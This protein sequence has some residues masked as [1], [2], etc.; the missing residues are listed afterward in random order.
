M[1]TLRLAVLPRAVMLVLAASIVVVFTGSFV[2]QVIGALYDHDHIFGLLPLLHV[3]RE[4]NLAAWMS[5]T[6]MLLCSATAWSLATS[7]ES[8]YISR[9]APWKWVALALFLMSMDETAQVHERVGSLVQPLLPDVGAL[10]FG[11]VAVGAL[12]VLAAAPFFFRFVLSL[13][14]RTRIQFVMAATLFFAG[15]LGVE[16]VTGEYMSRTEAKLSITY[17]FLSHTEELLEMLGL[18][19]LLRALLEYAGTRDSHD[20]V[21]RLTTVD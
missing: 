21:E 17:I 7:T 15:A 6:T 12:V 1:M 18:F 16:M 8:K 10:Y 14:P 5:S 20:Q 3:D 2:L 4:G 9:G 11:W 19:V 13:P